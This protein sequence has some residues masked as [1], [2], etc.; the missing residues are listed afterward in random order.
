MTKLT[1]KQERYCLAY[2][3]TG[4]GTD[5]YRLAYNAEKMSNEAIKAESGKLM[6]MPKIKARI[7]EL[8][9]PAARAAKIT[10]ESHLADLERLR[11]KAERTGD[12]GAAIRGEV[13][14]GRAAGLYVEKI[15]LTLTGSLAERLARA[16]KKL[17]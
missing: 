6:A 5:A 11:D 13:A 8:R 3:E 16:R 2:I 14:R 17:A 10:L 9:A 15:D 7:A 12:Y 4:K 1:A